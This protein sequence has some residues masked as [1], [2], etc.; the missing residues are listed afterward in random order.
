MFSNL[1]NIFKVED[2]RRKVLF[3]LAMIAVYRFG[4]A[5]RVP[6]VDPG[7]VAQL[8]EA[9]KSQGALGFLNLF[10]GGAFGSFSIFALGGMP[11]LT[12]SLIS[13][14]SSA[15]RHRHPTWSCSTRSCPARSSSSRH[16]S[17]ARRFSCGS[18]S[19]SA[20]AASRT[21]CRC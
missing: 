11:D 2:L 19:S 17:R 3:T 14:R 20:S 15:R 10:S 9:S 6:G 4:S 7:A 1:K 13:Q 21:A 18:V 8:R 16:S 12:A 5:L